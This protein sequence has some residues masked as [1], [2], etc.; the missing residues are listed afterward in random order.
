MKNEFQKLTD[1]D[2]MVYTGLSRTSVFRLKNKIKKE[3]NIKRNFLIKDDL[4]K[5]YYE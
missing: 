2:L 5:Y 1:K 3:L 4:N